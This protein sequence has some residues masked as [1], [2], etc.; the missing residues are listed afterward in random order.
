MLVKFTSEAAGFVSAFLEAAETEELM[1]AIGRLRLPRVSRS[2]KRSVIIDEVSLRGRR[3][4]TVLYATAPGHGI[5]IVEVGP[6]ADVD[7]LRT[8]LARMRARGWLEALAVCELDLERLSPLELKDTLRTFWE[9]QRGSVL[10]PWLLGGAPM[11][12]L[13][14]RHSFGK[15]HLLSAL[16]GQ[17]EARQTGK[18]REQFKDVLDRAAARPQLI[19]RDTGDVIMVAVDLLKRFADPASARALVRVFREIKPIRPFELQTPAA[20]APALELP[21]LNG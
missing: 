1:A 5:T 15:T 9:L 8:R 11:H 2:K 19:S 17:A 12:M 13:G 6:K 3:A 20:P 4:P 10:A 21:K 14:A 7:A 16:L 18:A